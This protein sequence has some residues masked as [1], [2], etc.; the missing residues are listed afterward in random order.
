M[1]PD[2][3]GGVA[4]GNAARPTACA[5]IPDAHPSSTP[6]GGLVAA[7]GDAARYPLPERAYFARVWTFIP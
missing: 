6:A 2:P 3:M 4:S 7:R 1:L 5:A